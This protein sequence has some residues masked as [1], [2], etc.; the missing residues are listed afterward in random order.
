MQ[1]I[2][3]AVQ[4]I[5]ECLRD[6]YGL[7]IDDP[8]FKETPARVAKSYA[9]I[10]SGVAKTQEQII[11][12]LKTAFPCDYGGMVVQ[13]GIKAFSMCPHH[14]LPV[15]YTVDVGYIPSLG[16]GVLGL[17]KLAR[18]VTVLAKRPVMQEQFTH[19]IT[20]ALSSL[21][22]VKGAAVRVCGIHYCMVMRGASQTESTTKTS[23]L[24]GVFKSIPEARAEFMSLISG[25]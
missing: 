7:D 11:K 19:E 22:G 23:D 14:L 8:N 15:V 18:I 20:S 1:K 13:C 9:E 3:L 17:S 6:E 2:E 21:A 12:I 25:K 4:S 16:G 24:T 5:L 10:F